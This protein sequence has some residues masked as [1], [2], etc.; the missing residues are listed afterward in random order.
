MEVLTLMIMFIDIGGH[1]ITCT[2]FTSRRVMITK[3]HISNPDRMKTPMR[4]RP[5]G[6][7]KID[8]SPV[9]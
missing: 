1:I 7:V 5:P 9:A 3:L 4:K 6:S 2:Y 8:D